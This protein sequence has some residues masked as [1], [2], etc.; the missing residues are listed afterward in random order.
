[1]SV[2]PGDRDAPS[3]EVTI[4]RGPGRGDARVTVT[5]GEVAVS[6]PDAAGD[7]FVAAAIEEIRRTL[8]RPRARPSC[9]RDPRPPGASGP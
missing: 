7:P 3:W 9:A 5:D 2:P 1:V 4:R 8:T 6:P